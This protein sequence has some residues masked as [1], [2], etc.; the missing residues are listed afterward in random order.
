[1]VLVG[2]VWGVYLFLGKKSSLVFLFILGNFVYVVFFCVFLV[3]VVCFVGVDNFVLD[4]EGVY[5]VFVLGVFVLG[6]GYVIWYSV[7]F[8][9]KLIIVV[10]V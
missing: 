6:C 8:F 2:M 10:I 9:I 1:M 3:G 5:Y 7:F 4:S